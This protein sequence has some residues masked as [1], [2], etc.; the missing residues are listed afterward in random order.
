LSSDTHPRL[1]RC[2]KGLLLVAATRLRSTSRRGLL[3]ETAPR[4]MDDADP[5]LCPRS[6]LRAADYAQL[7]FSRRETSII[8]KSL[9]S[10]QAAKNISPERTIVLMTVTENTL[11]VAA[12]YEGVSII[13][14]ASPKYTVQDMCFFLQDL[15]V[16]IEGIGHLRAQRALLDHRQ[17]A[18]A[19]KYTK[20]IGADDASK[21]AQPGK[22]MAAKS[23]QAENVVSVTKA[24]VKKEP[25][26]HD[27]PPIIT[28]R[29]F[30]AFSCSFILPK[31]GGRTK[32]KVS[33]IGDWLT[34]DDV[35]V[36]GF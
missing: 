6:S 34:G 17:L 7:P 14:N 26:D 29:I 12:R 8:A 23:T 22:K 3:V 35:D 13:H 31:A 24:D 15:G 32:F 19:R 30:G 25:P 16:Q 1:T 20:T 36:E 10:A 11:L 18:G 9:G 33:R 5:G 28:E 27:P 4:F 2:S 21:K